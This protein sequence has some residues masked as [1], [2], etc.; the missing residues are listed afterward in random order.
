M[1]SKLSMLLS[2]ILSSRTRPYSAGKRGRARSCRVLIPR[3]GGEH[4]V[5]SRP[6]MDVRASGEPF[7]GVFAFG[8][9]RAFSG[10]GLGVRSS[11]AL[12]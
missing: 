12:R 10:E 4:A 2:G 1:R 7:P 3:V 9:L 8:S 6:W 5:P 11:G